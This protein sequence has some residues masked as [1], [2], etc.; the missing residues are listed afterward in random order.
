M[1][2]LVG[3]NLELEEYC[4][5]TFNCTKPYEKKPVDLALDFL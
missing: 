5:Y 3:C 1:L 4:H 2:R